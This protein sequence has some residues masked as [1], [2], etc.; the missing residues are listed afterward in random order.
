MLSYYFVNIFKIFHII[1]FQL[2]FFLF[3]V[4]LVNTIFTRHFR[5]SF[6]SSFL[7]HQ[8]LLHIF[9]P[10]ILCS[11]SSSRCD[12]SVLITVWPDVRHCV[13]NDMCF[14]FL[15]A[16]WSWWMTTASGNW[17]GIICTYAVECRKRSVQHGSYNSVSG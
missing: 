14:V 6:L 16:H 4:F 7:L 5:F 10:T 11:S 8:N 3:F 2:A 13:I 12:I 1:R 17:V 15:R 9:S